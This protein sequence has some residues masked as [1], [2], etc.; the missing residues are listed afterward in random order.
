VNGAQK[1]FVGA[2]AAQTALCGGIALA[3]ALSGCAACRNGSSLALAGFLF[4]L[5]LLLEALR[6]GV[7]PFHLWASAFAFGVHLLLAADLLRSG[8][9]C[10]PCFSACAGSAALAGLAWLCDRDLLA[11]VP[12]LLPGAALVVVLWSSLPRA[13]AEPPSTRVDPAG[14][15]ALRLTVFTQA[16]CPYCDELR[17]RVMPDIL[18]EFGPRLELAWRPAS[19]LPAIRRTP[20]LVISRSLKDRPA[21]VLEGLPSV[22]SLR[23]ALRAVEGAP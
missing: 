9:R 8:L 22:E 5:G 3:E 16:D 4:Y 6:R 1:A 7:R 19:D 11:R 17:D 13:V 15:S 20:T 23:E 21:R 14:T 2:L 18:R 12:L 10:W